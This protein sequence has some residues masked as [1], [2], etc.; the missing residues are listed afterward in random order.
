MALE[1]VTSS[2]RLKDVTNT[3]KRMRRSLSICGS[4]S[5]QWWKTERSWRLQMC[6]RRLLCVT[7]G[8]H[9][10]PGDHGSMKRSSPW[11]LGHF[12]LPDQVL[13]NLVT[14]CHGLSRYPWWTV[15]CW[16]L[17]TRRRTTVR[18]TVCYGC[19]FVPFR[20]AMAS[21]DLSCFVTF[22]S[23]SATSIKFCQG[24]LRQNADDGWCL[25]PSVPMV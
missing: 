9:Y 6:F 10:V 25:S 17:E 14:F 5:V 8:L 3:C 13:S 20:S 22:Q 19:V 15:G 2:L 23:S 12:Y 11:C 4:S 24:L 21:W 18:P 7:L 1:G 16:I